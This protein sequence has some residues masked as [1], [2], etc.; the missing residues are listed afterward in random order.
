MS[1]INLKGNWLH[2][3]GFKPGDKVTV[4]V[5]QGRL[6]IAVDKKGD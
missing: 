6:N 2:E 3:A 5:S 4:I 1:K